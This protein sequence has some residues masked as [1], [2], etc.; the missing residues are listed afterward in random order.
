MVNQ[1]IWSYA[2]NCPGCNELQIAVQ[3]EVNGRICR[4]MST[5][6]LNRGIELRPLT[7]NSAG[8]IEKGPLRIDIQLAD[9]IHDA[10]PKWL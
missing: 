4:R 5:G 1:R 9:E 2:R 10:R 3:Q 6:V 8:K 7:F